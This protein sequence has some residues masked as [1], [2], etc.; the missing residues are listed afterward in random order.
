MTH[1]GKAEAARFKA[2]NASVIELAIKHG[3][4]LAT[5]P[6]SWRPSVAIATPCG[7]L[8]VT[9]IDTWIACCFEDPKWAKALLPHDPR[10]SPY[11]G[12]WNFNPG[13]GMDNLADLFEVALTR[14]LAMPPVEKPI[15]LSEL[16]KPPP[17]YAH[18]RL[19]DGPFVVKVLRTFGKVWVMHYGVRAAADLTAVA[20]GGR[21]RSITHAPTGIRVEHLTSVR[22]AVA[23]GVRLGE[24][25]PELGVGLNLGDTLTHEETTQLLAVCAEL[26]GTP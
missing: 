1:V 15:P 6:T 3:G 25:F 22:A 19:M 8:R 21:G 11:S 4:T 12:K 14:L 7:P 13:S 2:F 9:P 5:V 26:R 17:G 10:L 18:V 24:T 23:L 16:P 20:D